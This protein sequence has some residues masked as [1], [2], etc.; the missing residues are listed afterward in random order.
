VAEV[1]VVSESDRKS[2]DNMLSR[3]V[4][5]PAFTAVHVLEHIHV[6]HVH[7]LERNFSSCS[8]LLF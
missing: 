7:A 1:G 2:L 4:S 6:E 5:L 8:Q 3:F